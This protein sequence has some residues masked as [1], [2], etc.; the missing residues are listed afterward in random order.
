MKYKLA[1]F[2]FDGT[3]A[4]SF[5]WAQSIANDIADKH[6]FKRIEPSEQEVLRGFSARQVIKHLGVPWWKMPFIA[7]DVQSAM[8]RDIA[9]IA[10]FEGVDALFQDLARRGIILAIVSSNSE[11]NIRS[12]LGKQNAALVHFF[13]CGV[14]LFGKSAKIKKLLRRCKVLPGEAILIG[15]EIRDGEAAQKA[16]V[17]FGAVAW[18]YTHVEAL[19]AQAPHALFASMDDIARELVAI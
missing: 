19:E 10:L 18:G 2:D 14:S 5:P 13:E 17:A 7:R 6:R 9:M 12:V 8:A 15:D 1:I 3:L 11:Q 16:R 4:D